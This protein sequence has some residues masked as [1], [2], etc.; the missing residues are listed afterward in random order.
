MLFLKRLILS[1][2]LVSGFLSSYADATLKVFINAVRNQELRVF[3]PTIITLGE[4]DF[5]FSERLAV[6]GGSVLLVR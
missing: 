3:G 4:F 1:R 5:L 6:G 2:P